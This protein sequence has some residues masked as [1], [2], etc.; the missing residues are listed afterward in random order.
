MRWLGAKLTA[1]G[2]EV[3]ADVMRLRGGSD[4][5]RDLEEAL[6]LRSAKVLLVC[7]PSG[8]DKQGV[9][10]EIAMAV[11]IGKQLGDR[12]F[13]IPLRLEPYES[14][15]QIAQ[16]QYV[17]FKAGWAQGFTELA[18]LLSQFPSL[19][20]EPGR[21]TEA[22]LGAQ[23]IGAT[24]LIERQERLSSNWLLFRKLPEKVFYCEP[25]VGFQTE[26]F[27]QRNLHAWPVVPFKSG[28]LTFAPPDSNGM[29]GNDLPAKVIGEIETERF[30]E[31]GWSEMGIPWYEAGRV[32]SDLANQ[33]F[34][35]LLHHQGLSFSEGASGRRW[36]FGDVKTAPLTQVA[37]DWK[38]QK[39]R[40]QIVGQSEKRGTFWH[41]A[42][43]GQVRTSPVRHARISASLIFSNNGLNALDDPRKAHR[44]RRSFAKTWR[45]ARWRDM[46]LAFLWWI[47]KG[48]S[49]LALPVGQDRFFILSMPPAS[50]MSPVCVLHDGEDPPDEDDP[51]FDD[52]EWDDHPEYDEGGEE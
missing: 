26:R 46:M 50:F 9:R 22:W 34:E 18:E 47:S 20:K 32:F 36:W 45:N 12:E 25:P 41:Y 21:S 40:R 28:V 35:S 39:G 51:D 1:L 27:Q 13:I 48:K 23:R 33:A 14:P 11:G 6:R 7:T 17:D 29:M 8:L 5:S 38:H 44:L 19:R 24:R 42:I 49:E 52:S 30:L 3:W 16:A 10:N 4:W 31:R 15:F 2:Y 43:S 37:F